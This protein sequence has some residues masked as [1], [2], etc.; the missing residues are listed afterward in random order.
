[1]RGTPLSA[2][3]RI[4]RQHA[5]FWLHPDE[6]DEVVSILWIWAASSK[7]PRC[8]LEHRARLFL[9][10]RYYKHRYKLRRHAQQLAAIPEIA[11]E[12]ARMR[13]IDNRDEIEYAMRGLSTAERSV[14][15]LRYG[16]DFTG[17]GLTAAERKAFNRLH[18][19]AIKH[20][21]SRLRSGDD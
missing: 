4:A 8:Y 5:Q 19:R 2:L 14:I 20:M 6:L 15:W 18:N 13:A 16:H 17:N 12:D 3:Y 9:M 11:A 1:M 21:K 7:P 10:S